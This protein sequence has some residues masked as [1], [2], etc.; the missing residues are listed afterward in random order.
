MDTW[1]TWSTWIT[2]VTCCRSV[3]DCLERRFVNTSVRRCVGGSG[4]AEA[5]AVLG[6]VHLASIFSRVVSSAGR[7]VFVDE[8]LFI[9]GRG[10]G[11]QNQV[12]GRCGDRWNW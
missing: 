7:L 3:G 9:R 2:S 8:R 11:N 12:D 10:G 4:H 6:V 5:G 1:I